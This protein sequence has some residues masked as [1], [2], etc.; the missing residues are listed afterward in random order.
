MERGYCGALRAC[1]GVLIGVASAFAAPAARADVIWTLDDVIFNDGGT[2]TGTFTI[3]QY[4]YG[5][6]NFDI[7]TAG[8]SSGVSAYEYMAGPAG[9]SISGDKYTIT[10]GQNSPNVGELV[11]QFLYP[12]D[13]APT[14]S[15]DPIVTG[16]L[17]GPL[18]SFECDGYLS[19]NTC[20]L[21]S[22]VVP[23]R[24]VSGGFAETPEPASLPLLTVALA[25]L[26]VLRRRP[27][28]PE[29]L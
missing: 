6:A 2:A 16:S 17:S 7:T 22:V 3:N 12:L 21:N 19:G 29:S 13:T 27:V 25:G 23:I 28:G 15:I 10:F 18:D 8:G 4:G 20:S 1:C 14:G 9:I 5:E 26:V 24:I 11:L